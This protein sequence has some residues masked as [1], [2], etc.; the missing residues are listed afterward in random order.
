MA[1]AHPFR[2]ILPS[3]WAVPDNEK[4]PLNFSQQ[5]LTLLWG[6]FL[7]LTMNIAAFLLGMVNKLAQYYFLF[8]VR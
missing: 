8:K 5:P 4:T 6:V 7:I 1:T 2:C 3:V